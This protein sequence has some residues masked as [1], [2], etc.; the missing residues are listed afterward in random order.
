ME[1]LFSILGIANFVWYAGL[2]WIFCASEKWLYNP[3]NMATAM[4]SII[5]L[6]ASVFARDKVFN[7]FFYCMCMFLWFRNILYTVEDT[8]DLLHFPKIKQLEYVLIDLMM[9]LY[10]TLWIIMYYKE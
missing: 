2:R 5:F 4:V 6:T 9:V 8:I 3:I 7:I 1:Q 10:T